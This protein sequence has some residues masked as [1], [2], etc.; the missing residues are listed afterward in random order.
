MLRH[1]ISNKE[2]VSRLADRSGM[3]EG[4]VTSLL[5]EFARA[6]AE[7]TKTSG[8]FVV[9]RI[10]LIEMVESPERIAKN[11]S[12]GEPIKLPAKVNLRFEFASKLKRIVLPSWEINESMTTV[13][14]WKIP[15]DVLQAIDQKGGSAEEWKTLDPKG[16]AMDQ[17]FTAV[18]DACA[19]VFGYVLQME[20]R[21]ETGT[22]GELLCGYVTPATV[23]ERSNFLAEVDLAALEKEG[24]LET[25][26][27][28]AFRKNFEWLRSFLKEAAAQDMA[29]II[30]T[31]Y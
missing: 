18:L 3:S 12:T 31:F 15:L 9:P 20:G 16:H 28:E 13:S 30:M 2:L 29:L 7:E 27:V 24:V 22:F 1:L 11:P 19:D 10:G 6:A 8:G 4:S 25:K 17:E 5:E 23:K 14:L 21:F 26:T